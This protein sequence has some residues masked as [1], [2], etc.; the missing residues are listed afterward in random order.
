MPTCLNCGYEL[1]LLPRQKYKCSLCSKLYPKKEI[2]NKEFR[3]KNKLQK[4]LNI[5]DSKKEFEKQWKKFKKIRKDIEIMFKD[6]PNPK[7]YH[8]KWRVKNRDKLKN[9]RIDAIKLKA[10]DKTYNHRLKQR[11]A[12]WRAKQKELALQ[13]LE[14]SKERASNANIFQTPFT[15]SLSYLL[16]NS[17]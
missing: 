11:L 17:G 8:K 15:F 6:I 14:K 13:F 4:E 10:K 9:Y 12:Y 5:T 2:E 16:L 1:V 7:K 3:R